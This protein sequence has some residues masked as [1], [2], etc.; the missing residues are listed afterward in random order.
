MTSQNGD[1]P[2][3]QGIKGSQ[4][5][6]L[7]NLDQPVIRVQAGPGTG[8]TFGIGRRVVRLLHPLGLALS[9]AEVLV[10][11]FNRAI[12]R[13]LERQIRTQLHPF[14]LEVPTV[15]TIHSLAVQF[16]GDPTR[17]LLPH[18]QDVMVYD[19]LASNA[20]LR[21]KYESQPRAL[22]ALREH[23]AGLATHTALRQA[24]AGWLADHLAQLVGDV[25]RA[26]ER[27]ISLGTPPPHIYRHIIVDEF[28]DLTDIE[29][30]LVLR[31]RAPG[32]IFMALGDRKQSIYAFRGNA[33]H[34][35]EALDELVAPVE[36]TDLSMD[37]CQRCSIQVVAIGNALMQLENEPLV[38]VR[39]DPAEVR[40]FHFGTPMSEVKGVAPAVLQTYR[41]HPEDTHLVMVTRRQ[42]GYGLRDE[43]RQLDPNVH[44]QTVFAEDILE[45][46][47]VREAFLLLSTLGEPDDAATLRAWVGY[48]TVVDG[49]G[50]K[51][52]QRNADAYIK[53]KATDGVLSID[54]VQAL[55]ERSIGEFAGTGKGGLLERLQRLRNL[56]AAEDKTVSAAQ[57]AANVL[58]G[59]R[60]IG[61]NDL[62]GDLARADIDRLRAEAIRLVEAEKLEFPALVK[63]MRYRIATREPLGESEGINILI[64]TV[65]G[66]KGLTAD[67]VHIVGL[68]D[69]ALPGYYDE[70]STGLERSEWLDEQRR[71]LYVSLTRAKKGMAISM[72]QRAKPGYIQRLN[73]AMPTQGNRYWKTLHLSR[74]LR[75][76][77]PGL[78]P[79]SEDGSTWAG[80]D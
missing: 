47:P 58:S 51:A 12:A 40:L 4:V 74:F 39:D 68:I 13:D 30:R 22:R 20:T 42:W 6:P 48:K 52:N 72:A 63:R 34:G 11:T 2:W 28:Q 5:L 19:L 80:F 1:E 3:N 10:C 15:S 54:K 36:V 65:W 75:D 26:L 55:A 64:V 35:L 49:K 59:D 62:R 78:L 45:T 41:L 77:D 46:W 17:F 67:W 9:P 23:E 18:E 44:V 24:A 27:Q 37:E 53:L 56:W 29:A 76:L 21:A 57:T 60:W 71:L 14:G 70:D 50:F 16:I 43:I 38:S 66:A 8:K 79:D 25:P 69:E 33:E 73:L 32:S 7:I 31:L 61:R